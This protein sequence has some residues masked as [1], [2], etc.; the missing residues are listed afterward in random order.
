[1]GDCL[2]QDHLARFVV[3]I[4][5]QLDL[6][7]LYAR[8]ARR[9]GQPYAPEILVGL[10]FYAYATGVSRPERSNK[11]PK[12]PP[13][14]ASFATG[15][16]PHNTGWQAYFAE[17]GKAPPPEAD[18]KEKRA[19]KLRTVLG[20]ALY[21]RR[22]GTVEPVVGQLKEILGFRQFS[23]RGLANVSGEWCLVC[24]A[25]NLRRLHVLRAG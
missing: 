20:K 19:W 17:A 4:V 23:L 15:R 18:L 5:A 21:R 11:A 7:A 1:L 2:P 6:S 22:K 16:D 25:F 10:L 24:L 9:G 13:R 3:D 14:F 12:K 8:Y